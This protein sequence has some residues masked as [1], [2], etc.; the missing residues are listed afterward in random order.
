MLLI[1]CP[2]C[3]EERPELEFRNAGEAHI[4]RS[5]NIAAESDEDFE[6]FFFIRSNPKG[7]IFERWRH[8][9][10]CARFFNAVRDTVSDKFVMTYKA[11]EPK[12]DLAK[13]M[14][15]DKPAA[16]AAEVDPQEEKAKKPAAKRAAQKGDA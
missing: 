14:K 1:R 4:A 6:K 9:H 7:I 2:Y 12:P 13:I 15:T 5:T 16:V 11:G 8:I 3:E 10:G